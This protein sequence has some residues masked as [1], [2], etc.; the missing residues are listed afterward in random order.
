MRPVLDAS[1][2][3]VDGPSLRDL[4][5]QTGQEPAPR[6]TVL[7]QVQRF[8]GIGL[9][10]MEECGELGQVNAVPPVVVPRISAYPAHAVAGRPLADRVRLRRIAGSARQRLADE[11]LQPL[12]AGVGGRTD[13]PAHVLSPGAIECTP[14]HV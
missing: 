7:P 13:W 5:L 12:L 3:H 11:A 1:A 2:K 8:R 6:R 14:S 4:S 10:G 9:G